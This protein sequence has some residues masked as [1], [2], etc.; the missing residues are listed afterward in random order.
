[1]S[2]RDPRESISPKPLDDR[3]QREQ[4]IGRGS[5][6]IIYKAYDRLLQRTVAIK[7]MRPELRGQER[8]HTRFVREAQLCGRLGHPNIVPVYDVGRFEGGPAIVM[9]L[10]AG[11]SLRTIIRTTQVRM[12][13]MLGWFTQVC[14]GLAFAHDQGI[15]HRYIKPAHIFVGDFGQVVLTDWGLA[16]SMRAGN[17]AEE[18]PPGF[19]PDEVT[20]IGDVVG[21]PAYMA[22]EQAEGRVRQVDHRADVYALGAILYEILTGT[23]PYEASRSDEVLREVR[24]GSPEPPRQRAPHRDIP[25]ALEAVTLK[26]MARDPAQRFQSALD[27]AA[28]IEAQFESRPVPATRPPAGP[29]TLPLMRRPAT[30]RPSDPP[31]ELPPPEPAARGK[32]GRE[33]AALVS[34]SLVP[35]QTASDP[36]TAL[37]EGRGE[38]NAWMR[39][40]QEAR[41][42]SSEARRLFANL[43]PEP[44]RRMLADLWRLEG[45]SRDALDRA[46]HHFVQAVESLGKAGTGAEARAA[47]A[48]LHRDAW[49]A[50]EA[51]GD[52]V[53]AQFHRARA[54]AVDD[55]ALS[56]ELAR[57]SALSVHSDPAGAVVDLSSLDDRSTVWTP[58]AR[59]RLGKTP[60]SS[61]TVSASR[62][63]LRLT[64]PDGLA[65]RMPLRLEPGES[66]VVE[67]HLPRSHHVPAGFLFIAGGRFLMGADDR[68]PGAGQ[69]REVDV[70]SFCMARSPVT[71]EDYF[72][73]L[74]DLLAVGGRA[75]PR[76]PRRNGKAVVR[77]EH[78]RVQWTDDVFAPPGSPVRFVSQDDALAYAAWLGR[79]LGARL[80][81]PTEMEWEYAAG[82]ADGR[83]Y[84]WGDRFAP[85]LA[86]NRWRRA[87][88]PAPLAGFPEDES[89]F[90]VRNVAGGVS[91][92]TGTPA[93]E[94][95]RA[96]VRGGS[97]RSRPDQCRIGARATMPG[98]STHEGI[99]IRLAADAPLQETP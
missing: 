23:R 75:E 94:P 34:M 16:K 44:P 15:I 43:P 89:P 53:S 24:R 80:R 9:A 86:D 18:L 38:A 91:E 11:R 49:R 41:A 14:N 81:L 25:A 30:G 73:F 66:R 79:R 99:G 87:R 13:R 74:E 35:D 26:A 60:L 68:A 21:T 95:G 5:I 37:A 33:V 57:R 93:D 69:P 8:Q 96:I 51:H 4:E 39:H 7:V 88:G 83:A 3:Y 67:V 27:L 59:L 84:P 32:G 71:W 45:Q 61:R 46:A 85:G 50:A 62:A 40:W 42:L 65:A 47:L 63:W 72:E 29:E 19:N 10:L 64:A 56:G 82:G 31:G 36:E 55:G 12:G 48:R 52:L 28:N 77:V 98:P 20:R 78:T 1:M 92:W 22:P 58:G 97:W 2:E 17:A 6:G 76:F 90:G 70:Q 54:E